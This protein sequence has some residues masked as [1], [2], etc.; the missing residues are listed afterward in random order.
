MKVLIDNGHGINTKG[1]KSPDGSLLEYKYCREIARKVVDVLQ[2]QGVDA[3]LLVPE[4][5]DIPLKERVR[6]TNLY[7][8]GDTILISIHV[9]AAGNGRD[10]MAANGWSV[11]VSNNASSKSKVLADHIA[12]STKKEGIKVRLQY[13]DRSYW[14]KNL[15]ILKNTNCPAVLTENLF[16]D[17]KNDVKFLLSDE[18]KSKII[19]IHVNGILS[20]LTSIKR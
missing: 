8:S 6:R 16:M 15:Y 13:S 3:E 12:V 17:N 11:F 10:W 18:G 19:E 20:Y 1:K 14:V 5:E 4:E 9:D 7:N 2:E